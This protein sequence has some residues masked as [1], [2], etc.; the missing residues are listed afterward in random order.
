[1]PDVSI[2][3]SARDNF[4][5]TLRSMSANTRSFD[6][7]LDLMQ[8]KLTA[9][10]R[11][12]ASLTVDVADAKRALQ[13]AQKAYRALGDEAT[14]ADRAAARADFEAAQT[15]LDNLQAKLKAVTDA[16]R[17]TQNAMT[18]MA[19]VSTKQSSETTLAL[20]KLGQAGVFKML[21]DSAAGFAGWAAQSA[22]GNNASTMLSS[23]LSGA[24]SGA[25]LGSVVPGIGTAIGAGVGALAGGISGLTQIQSSKDD[26]YREYVQQAVED[27]WTQRAEM[28]STGSAIAGGR[29]TD[30]ISFATLFGGRDVAESFLTD[31]REMAKRTPFYYDDLTAMSKQLKVFGFALDEILPALQAVGDTGAAL[32]LGTTDMLYAETAIGRMRST[33]KVSLEYLNMLTERG[34]GAT[35]WLA[36][37]YGL[38]M[39][40]TYDKISKGEF[41]GT[42]VA[43]LILDKMTELYG[44]AMEQQSQTFEGLTST[45]EGMQQEV[46]NAYGAGY[47]DTRKEGIQAEIDALDGEMGRKLQE[48]YNALGAWEADLENK[49]EEYVRNAITAAMDSEE[50]QNAQA[51]DDAAEMGRIIAEAQIAGQNEYLANEGRDIQLQAQ[52]ELIQSVRDDENLSAAYRTAGYDLGQEFSKGMA[53]GISFSGTGDAAPG[54]QPATEGVGAWGDID[55]SHASGLQRVPYNNYLA[56]LHEGEQVLTAREARAGSSGASVTITGNQFTV[57]EEA[58]IDK[59]A[60]A[61]YD[62]IREQALAAAP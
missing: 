54:Y 33:D 40:D 17:E 9:L 4:S 11:T 23:T 29:E 12:K 47:N 1:M 45:L 61:L 34:I 38:S 26:A 57:R 18:S 62:R 43:Q 15:N 31:T 48:A 30:L 59:I 52:L 7:E 36:D 28:L 3:V 24:A 50:Y 35:Q 41:S 55:G 44:G 6:K 20:G 2:A 19:G 16:T 37:A 42:E 8:S 58:D 10:G 25:A 56:V 51:N 39:G 21:G 32:G 22:L 13:E 49:K 14:E 46:Q 60:W 53:S 27:I 5:A